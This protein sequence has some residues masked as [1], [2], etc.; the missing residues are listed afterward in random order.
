MLEELQ[1]LRLAHL[2]GII[3]DQCEGF[4]TGS[5]LAS[6]ASWKG[7]SIAAP[8]ALRDIGLF[9]KA[10]GVSL[11]DEILDNDI[12]IAVEGGVR[13][14]RRKIDGEDLLAINLKG[15]VLGA[16]DAFTGKLTFLFGGVVRWCRGWPIGFGGRLALFA[17]EA[18]VLIAQALDFSLSGAKV[19]SDGF[20]QIEQ[21]AD[22]D[23]GGLV[24]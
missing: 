4:D 14:K 23:A 12:F 20:D 10:D 3:E 22:E 21:V 6:V 13:R 9:V 16:L 8:G 7:R 15:S 18:V 17:F 19:S 2:R 5:K 11:K 1:D 24:G